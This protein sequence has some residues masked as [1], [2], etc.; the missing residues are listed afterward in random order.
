MIA[1]AWNNGEHKKSVAGYGLKIAASDRDK[2]F[3]KSW[4]TVIIH[5]PN[6]EEVEVNTDKASFWN[7]SCRE[8]IDKKIGQWLIETG[9]APWLKGRPPKFELIPQRERYFELRI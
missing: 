5:L 4:K 3:D 6:G 1:T 8:L 9:N 7:Q 2:Y